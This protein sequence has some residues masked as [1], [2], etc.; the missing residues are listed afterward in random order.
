M[1]VIASLK[2]ITTFVPTVKSIAIANFIIYMSI[3]YYAIGIRISHSTYIK[4]A[5]Q[6]QK[7]ISS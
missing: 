2:S 3:V 1:Y 4:K 5:D 7:D 6:D